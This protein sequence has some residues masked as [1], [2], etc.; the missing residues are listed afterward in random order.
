MA[1][2]VSAADCSTQL[3]VMSGRRVMSGRP[4]PGCGSGSPV[5][6][7]TANGPDLYDVAGLGQRRSFPGSSTGRAYAEVASA[8]LSSSANVSSSCIGE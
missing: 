4:P 6:P 5:C 7:T 3:I 1:V 2:V 8:C